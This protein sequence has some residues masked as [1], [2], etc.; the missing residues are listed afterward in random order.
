MGNNKIGQVIGTYRDPKTTD[1]LNALAESNA[2]LNLVQLDLKDYQNYNNFKDQIA[3]I[4][5]D[6]GRLLCD[7]L[8]II[9]K[10]Q[11]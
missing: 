9:K 8:E 11:V 1:D 6:K 7:Y 2:N 5:G 10:L 3:S 4:V